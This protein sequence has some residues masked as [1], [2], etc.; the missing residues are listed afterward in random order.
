[1]GIV[2]CYSMDIYCNDP[3]C[4]GSWNYGTPSG[5]YIGHTRSECVREARSHGWM[6]NLKRDP[7]DEMAN[8]SGYCLCPKHSKKK[9][10]S[11]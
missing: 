6:I 3:E 11:R 1:M 8:G 10:K 9:S 2:A 7:E 5:Q 4:V